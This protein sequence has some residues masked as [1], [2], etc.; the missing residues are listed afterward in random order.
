M[1]RIISAAIFQVKSIIVVMTVAVAVVMMIM[2][3]TGAIV[4]VR[5]MLE[6]DHGKLMFRF[7]FQLMLCLGAH[8]VRCTLH[9]RTDYN[10]K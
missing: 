1:V 2:M 8:V 3:M 10:F 7:I 4:M 9:L 6:S 5:L